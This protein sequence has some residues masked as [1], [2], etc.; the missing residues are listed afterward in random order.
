ML[1]A[2]LALAP[3][4]AVDSDDLTRMIRFAR[5]P[6]ARP[7]GLVLLALSLTACRG[8]EPAGAAL[9]GNASLAVAP[10]MQRAAQAGGPSFLAM[11][12]VHGVLTP[13][14]GG[15]SYS[16]DGVF[17]GDSA[18]L[19][20]NVTFPGSTARYSLALSA[21]DSAGDTLFRSLGDVVASSGSNAPVSA[22]MSYVAADTAVRWIFL[23]P[24]DSLVLFEDSLAISATGYDAREATIAPVHLG[25]S[26]RDSSIARVVATGPSSARVIASSLDST[27]W[28]VA[29]AFNGVADSVSLHVAARVGSVLLD[30][31][32]VRMIAG[33]AASISATVLDASGL[34]LDRAVSFVS[35]DTAIAQVTVLTGGLATAP[36][37]A[38][39]L[40]QVAQLIGLRAGTTRIVAASGGRADTAVVVVDPAPVATVR[41]IPDSIALLPRDS[42]RFSV[43]LLAANGDTL[44]GRT[45]KWATGNPQ[46]TTV[47]AAGTVLAGATGRDFVTATSEGVA[48]SAWV[49]VV[50]TGTSIVR[51]VVSPKTL[52]LVSLGEKGQLVAQ[53]YAGDSS[54]VPGRYSWSVRQGTKLL[55]VDSLG[56]VTPLAVGT[57]WII[58]TE[59]G[60]TADS[61]QVTVSDLVQPTS[62]IPH[63]FGG[64]SSAGQLFV[65]SSCPTAK[66]R[67]LPTAR[68]ASSFAERAKRASATRI[69]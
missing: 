43:V 42:A 54:L 44:T 16:A 47:D 69:P 2:P 15:G 11:R 18:T 14:A 57:A 19:E 25:W 66:C 41:I 40:P 35:L 23:A 31:D 64:A 6:V 8:A 12:S 32:T 56:G 45:I 58:A 21:V 51:T 48:D 63:A 36:A 34:M 30:A 68:S 62:G 38:T 1:A 7:A 59:K 55:A 10:V 37:R 17:D 53:G 39:A 13:L 24:A 61:A 65:S 9:P 27:V 46:V 60:G 22:I 20:F 26:S 67:R 3:F 52:H 33:N 5:H 50:T 49:N 28:I 29:R 4:R